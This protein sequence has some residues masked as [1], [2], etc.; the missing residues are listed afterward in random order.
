MQLIRKWRVEILIKENI[1]IK[2]KS[3]MSLLTALHFSHELLAKQIKPGDTVIDATI[4]NGHDTLFLAK[5]VGKQGKVYGFDIQKQAVE[6]TQTRLEQN[7]AAEQVSLFC[8][9]HETIA[10]TVPAGQLIQGAIFNLGYLPRGDKKIVTHADTTI[11]AASQILN[12][13]ATNGLLLLVLYSGHAEGFAEK[14]AILPFVQSLPQENF[15]VLA[16]H[17]INQKNE[18]PYLIAIQ[19]K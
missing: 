8:Q 17:F 2:E 10:Q 5:L 11:E 14:Q 13:L 1:V 9:G 19:K 15:D 4:G 7:D 12:R 16:Y 18:P 6:S 3:V